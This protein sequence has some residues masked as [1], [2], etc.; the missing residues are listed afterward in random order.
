MMDNFFQALQRLGSKSDK[1][2]PIEETAEFK[3]L[4]PTY[5]QFCK[6]G[7]MPRSDAQI[8]RDLAELLSTP[9]ITHVAFRET[10]DGTEL[11]LGTVHVYIKDVRTGLTYDIGEFIIMINPL[12]KRLLFDNITRNLRTRYE[13]QD[14][15]EEIVYHHP[16][17][18]DNGMMC[19]ETNLLHEYLTEGKIAA[20]ARI[21]V[22]ALHTVDER[23]F[24]DAELE[25]WPLKGDT[26]ES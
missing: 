19:I 13:G 8:L 7:L 17:I 18:Y 25:Y 10:E 23:P 24:P 22:R 26:H 20:V 21:L 1:I 5:L 14:D 6:W 15:G 2:V 11:M 12:K 3:A 9:G 4:A 16:H